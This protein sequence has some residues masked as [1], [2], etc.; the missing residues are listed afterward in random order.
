[1][2]IDGIGTNKNIVVT[3]ANGFVGKPLIAYLRKN[4]YQVKTWSRANGN[5]N[6]TND[7]SS[8]I[9]NVL[10]KWK[11]LLEDIDTIIHL[12][13][14]AHQPRGAQ[15]DSRYFQI[16]RDG[17]LNLAA[18]AQAA[19]VKRFIFL[20]SAKVFGEGGDTIYHA[21]T[22]PAPVD[23]YAQS[24]WQAEQLLL[25]RFSS[26]MEIVI[27]RPPLV[28]AANAKANF[29][30]LMKCANLPIPLP[31]AGIDNQRSMIGLDNLIDLI[32]LCLHHPAAAGKTFLCADERPYSLPEVVA[33]IRRAADRPPNL[34]HFPKPLLKVIKAL[35]GASMAERLF[36]NFQMDCSETWEILDW[37]PPFTMEQILRGDTWSCTV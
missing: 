10:E 26:S 37:R 19:G 18:A 33:S 1:M 28:Y 13:G 21:S 6:L 30:S 5:Y 24:K 14:L 35:L 12:A 32:T 34:V 8:D 4:R 7:I 23:A 36:G 2:K 16:N 29:A 31:V 15:D 27:L 20:S 9:K 11:V 25:E 3:G 17:T 22:A